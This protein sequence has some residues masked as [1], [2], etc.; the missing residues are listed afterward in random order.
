MAKVGPRRQPESPAMASRQMPTWPSP[1]FWGTMEL[2]SSTLFGEDI[3]KCLLW[4]I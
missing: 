1:L 4:M 2:L 3:K